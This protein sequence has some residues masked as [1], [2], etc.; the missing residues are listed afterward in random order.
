MRE[1]GRACPEI[2]S[3][4]VSSP[5]SFRS[6]LLRRSHPVYQPDVKIE[7]RYAFRWRHQAERSNRFGYRFGA[8]KGHTAGT[9]HNI[10]D[11]NE[12]GQDRGPRIK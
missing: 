7:Q 9:S 11:N 1:F 8:E 2:A 6:A 5:G 4:P 12:A 10:D 3:F